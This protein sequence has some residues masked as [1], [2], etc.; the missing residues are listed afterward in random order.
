MFE[1][2]QALSAIEF[3]PFSGADLAADS[4]HI[5]NLLCQQQ[6]VGLESNVIDVVVPSRMFAKCAEPNLG[7]ASPA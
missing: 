3:F 2:S 7:P 5:E 6:A 4:I 1:L